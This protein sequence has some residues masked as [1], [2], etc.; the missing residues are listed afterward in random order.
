MDEMTQA[1]IARW[2]EHHDRGHER[3]V[4][5][6]E[7]DLTIRHMAEDMAEMKEEI[8]WMRRLLV[9]Q[10]ITFAAGIILYLINTVAP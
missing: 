1:E 7:F 10:L 5:R 9:T 4:G 3:Y 8:R 6:G 2:I